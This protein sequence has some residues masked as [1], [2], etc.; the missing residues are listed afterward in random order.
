MA[1]NGRASVLRHPIADF[2]VTNVKFD[3]NK[4]R[5]CSCYDHGFGLILST[6][7]LRIKLNH[8]F[9]QICN[10][11][12]DIKKFSTKFDFLKITPILDA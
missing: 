5:N 4:F 3:M 2:V 9:D 10:C 7:V 6:T 8:R 11:F 12:I 1:A